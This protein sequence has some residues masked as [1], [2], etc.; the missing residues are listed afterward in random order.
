MKTFI[1]YIIL[2]LSI[3]CFAPVQA[4]LVTVSDTAF[5]NFL[6]NYYKTNEIMDESCQQLDTAKAQSN[7]MGFMNFGGRGTVETVEE[8]M[9]F[10]SITSL[11]GYGNNIE[12]INSF[13]PS[14]ITIDFHLNPLVSVPDLSNLENLEQIYL[15][16]TELESITGYSNCKNLKKV[17]ILENKLTE[18]E[19]FS[20]LPALEIAYLQGNLLTFEDLDPLSQ[21][22]DFESKFIYYPQQNTTIDTSISIDRYE[23]LE[24]NYTIDENVKGLKFQWFK[25]NIAI[26]GATDR[27]LNIQSSRVEDSG[28]YHIKVWS[29]ALGEEMGYLRSGNWGVSINNKLE[30][31]IGESDFEFVK[32]ETCDNLS[33]T[34]ESFECENR[35]PL[36]YSL[37]NDN[38]TY[39]I[40]IGN[41]IFVEDGNYSLQVEDDEL[42]LY[43]I[44]NA[45]TISKPEYCTKNDLPEDASFSP[46][47]DKIND[48]IT[49]NGKGKV[50]ITDLNGTVVRT[51]EIPVIWN[52]TDESG[53]SLP[54]GLYLLFFDD[55]TIKQLSLLR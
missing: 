12:T 42:C 35:N 26:E 49:I 10:T 54:V 21:I 17:N 8:L 20:L 14:L 1:R 44:K 38:N 47:G 18:I 39:P 27:N 33:V 23:P 22:P 31:C 37:I 3:Y 16:K 11:N 51:F 24:I 6:C 25:N 53:S 43:T 29:E 9:Y 55:G 15:Y 50:K 52:G 46:N 2:L 48:E 36:S 28:I 7:I 30:Q 45:I 32:N 4:Q 19:D 34:L 5:A 41:E 13:S 40:E